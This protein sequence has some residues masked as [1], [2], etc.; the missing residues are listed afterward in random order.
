MIITL[1]PLQQQAYFACCDPKMLGYRDLGRFEKQLW[2]KGGAAGRRSLSRG[3]RPGQEDHQPKGR[4]RR[5][6]PITDLLPG[7]LGRKREG[8][9]AQHLGLSLRCFMGRRNVGVQELSLRSSNEP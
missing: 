8:G 6:S 2:A 9:G 5:H 4:W 7:C 1:N 3:G